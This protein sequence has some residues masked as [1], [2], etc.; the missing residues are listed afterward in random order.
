MLLN[1]APADRIGKVS[2]LGWATGYAGG[3][4]AL[5]LFLLTF[6]GVAGIGPFWPGEVEA[7]RLAGPMVALWMVVFS[8]PLLLTRLPQTKQAAVINPLPKKENIIKLFLKDKNLLK[9]LI[10]SALYRDGLTT[11]F[12]VGGIYAASQFQL[13][14]TEMLIFAVGLNV[15]AAIGAFLF[16]FWEDKIGS[17]PT[18][19]V[20]LGGLIFFGAIILFLQSALAFILVSLALGFFIGPAQAAGRSMIS[21]L[22]TKEEKG[23]NYGFY[24]MTGKSAAFFGPLMF[25]L[26]VDL[27]GTQQAGLGVILGLWLAGLIFV[28]F[29]KE[30]SLH[31]D[32]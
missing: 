26:I 18:I 21:R 11:L 1:I 2:A 32:D 6:I 10:G 9:F 15:T 29:V 22:S 25:G 27:T 13:T 28:I 31:A 12:A 16:S 5:I 14:P 17:K 23:R 8:L 7:G 3:L 30:N 19:I 4:S 24:A 20:S